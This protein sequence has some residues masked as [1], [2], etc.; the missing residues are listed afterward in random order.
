MF[1]ILL[2]SI[3]LSCVLV[4]RSVAQNTSLMQQQKLHR[5]YRALERMYVDEV[6]M[7]PLVEAAIRSMLEELDPH[8]VYLDADEMKEAQES[9]AGEFSGIGVEFNVLKDTVI[10][11]NTVAGGPA[12]RAGVL[13]NAG[14]V[15]ANRPVSWSCG[16]AFRSTRSMRPT[17]RR[18]ESATSR[19]TVSGGPPWTNSAMRCVGWDP[20]KG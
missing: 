5:V 6:E 2:V 8:S 12:E 15:G 11:V 13:P 7:N 16:T 3:S 1:R 10:V 17:K 19:S 18:R 4:G 20:S 9:F 14:S